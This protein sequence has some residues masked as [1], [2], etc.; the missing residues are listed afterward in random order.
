VLIPRYKE[1]HMLNQVDFLNKLGEL[2][3]EVKSLDDSGDP[4]VIEETAARLEGFN[5]GPPVLM[6]VADFLRCTKDQLLLEID[7][8]AKLPDSEIKPREPEKD[9]SSWELKLQHIAVMVYYFKELVPLRRGVPEAW[10]EIDELY[11]HD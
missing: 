3:D 8:I 7:K 10:D 1:A 6:P 4:K 9:V 11:V 5:Y 2:Q